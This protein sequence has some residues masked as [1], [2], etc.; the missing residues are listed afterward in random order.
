[1]TQ[2]AE[3]LEYIIGELCAGNQAQFSRIVGIN[4]TA[5]NK[6]LNGKAAEVGIRLTDTYINRICRAFPMVNPDYLRCKS[7]YP[8]ELSKDSV[9]E[10]YEKRLAEK[11]QMIELLRKEIE[12]Q[13][14]MLEK[15]L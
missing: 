1:M 10:Q 11:D 4:P 9:K 5:I 7:D 2:E 12:L 8:G 3:R 13:R 6:I 14:R 15:L